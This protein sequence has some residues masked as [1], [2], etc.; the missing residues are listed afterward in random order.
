MEQGA[1]STED[2]SAY[3]RTVKT[4]GRTSRNS[5][6]V[7]AP[8][9]PAHHAGCSDAKQIVYRIEREQ[10]GGGKRDRRVFH[11]IAQHSYKISVRHIVEHHDKGT[12]DHGDG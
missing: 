1:E 2:Q 4:E 6:I 8:Q 12:E 11:R 7:F 5:V 9:R 3:E 10:N